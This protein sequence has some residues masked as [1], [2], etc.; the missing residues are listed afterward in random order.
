M[1][2]D[3]AQDTSPAALALS[4]GV[5]T[6]LRDAEVPLLVGGGYA[7]IRYT[8][9]VRRMKEFDVFVRERDWPAV[10][11]AL[12]AAGIDTVLTFPHWLGKAVAGDVFVDIIYGSGNGVAP[13]DDD[14]FRHATADEVLGIAVKLVPR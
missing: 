14:W 5:L 10:V 9:I 1:S 6:A 7:F 3:S 12:H 13:V 4:G 8:G 2:P 11:A